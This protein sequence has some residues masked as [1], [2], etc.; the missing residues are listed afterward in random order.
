LNDVIELRNT[1]IL[2]DFDR[3]QSKIYPLTEMLVRLHCAHCAKARI[4]AT[5]S[6]SGRKKTGNQKKYHQ[7]IPETEAQHDRVVSFA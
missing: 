4:T 2:L 1:E 5:L 6:E 3:T 7:Q